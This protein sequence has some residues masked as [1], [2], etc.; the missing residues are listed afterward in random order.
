[1]IIDGIFISSWLCEYIDLDI[2]TRYIICSKNIGQ[3]YLSDPQEL[4]SF[5][6]V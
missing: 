2:M 3:Y 1:M 4:W 5:S 6:N